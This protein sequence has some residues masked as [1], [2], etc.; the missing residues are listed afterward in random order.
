MAA[1]RHIVTAKA[2][3]GER[4]ATVRGRRTLSQYG[5]AGTVAVVLALLALGALGLAWQERVSLETEPVSAGTV[6]PVIGV[7]VGLGL[8]LFIFGITSKTPLVFVRRR[9]R[10]GGLGM[11][12]TGILMFAVVLLLLAYHRQIGDVLNSGAPPR[13]KPGLTP[14]PGPAPPPVPGDQVTG[15]PA[16]W[17][18]PIAIIAG[19]VIGMAALALVFMSRRAVPEETTDVEEPSLAEMHAVV[20]AGR[21][22]LAD[23]DEPRAAVIG[24]YTAMERA[25]AET[26]LRR[27][28]ADTAGDLLDRA[29]RTGLLSPTG[30]AAA[31]ELTD[32]FR[33]A[34]FSRR[35]VEPTVRD[36]AVDALSRLES[37]LRMATILDPDAE[38]RG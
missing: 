25:L 20:V 15:S 30:A 38:A 27:A 21:A 19:F 7:L 5:T 36:R 6:I 35:D 18:W 16:A 10:T 33:Q 34:R 8:A 1:E 32:L 23:I 9:Q 37:E 12:V 24:A 13:P 14:V 4:G 2:R 26:G 17:N 22:A 31:T 28:P 3:P 11:A 29:G